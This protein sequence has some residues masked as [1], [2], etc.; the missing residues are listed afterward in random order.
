MGRATYELYV[1]SEQNEFSF[2]PHEALNN[3]QDNQF[4]TLWSL[5]SFSE[6]LLASLH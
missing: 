5:S 4:P 3:K 6:R 1:V 2:L